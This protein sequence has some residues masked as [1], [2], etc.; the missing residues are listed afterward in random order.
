MRTAKRLYNEKRV[1]QLK[2]N[3]KRTWSL[4]NEIV[5]R[6]RRSRHLLSSFQADSQ[7]VS[8]PNQTADLFC[9]SITNIGP[10]LAEKIFNSQKVL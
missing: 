6:K 5:N 3:I 9:N 8:D 7:G 4:L 2:S 1:E 10:N